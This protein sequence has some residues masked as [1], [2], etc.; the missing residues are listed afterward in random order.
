MSSLRLVI[1]LFA[2]DRAHEQLL[3]P[4]VQ[5]IA[6]EE[7]CRGH[8][9]VQSAHGGHGRVIAEFKTYQRLRESGVGEMPDLVVAA[10][11]ANCASYASA[12]SEV[13]SAVSAP[14]EHI[15]VPACPD[16]H[17]ERWY[18]ADLQAFHEIVG[19]TPSVPQDKCERDLYKQILAQAI[20]ETE[21]P[22]MLGPLEFAPDIAHGMD[23]FRAGKS[24]SSLK[25][26]VDDLRKRI[27]R[28]PRAAPRVR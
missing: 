11:D 6:Q 21:Q 15:C 28:L 14:F 12:V 5:R 22:A 27:R 19:V 8:V 16:P 7:D 13:R 1:D 24:E 10:I 3:R 17:I 25:H 4:M 18:L 23:F 2:E 26:F 9:R 20:T